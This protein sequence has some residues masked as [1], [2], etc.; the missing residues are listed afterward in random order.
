MNPI[1]LNSIVFLFLQAVNSNKAP[2][3]G[4]DINSSINHWSQFK[5]NHSKSNENA[6]YEATRYYTFLYFSLEVYFYLFSF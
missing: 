2:I 3:Y 1:L 5:R 6:T 4:T